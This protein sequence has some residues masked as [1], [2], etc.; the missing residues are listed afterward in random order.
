[1]AATSSDDALRWAD[2][3]PGPI[4]ISELVAITDQQKITISAKNKGA[5]TLYAVD[6]ARNI[7]ASLQVV[8]GNFEKHPGMRVDLIADVCRGSD[9]FRIHAL[10]R[11]LHNQYLGQD[12]NGNDKYSNGDNVF[13]QNAPPN[14]SSDPQIGNMTCGIV[15]RFRT[16]QVFPKI[17]APKPDWYRVGAIH[18]PLSSRLTDRKQVKYRSERIETLRGQIIR[19]L[20]NGEA[21]RVG[22]LDDPTGMVP[23]NGDLVAYRGGGHTVVIVGYSTD[24]MQFLYIDPWGGGSMMEYQGGIAGNTFPGKCSQIGKLIVTYD[25]DRR[26]KK[27]DTANNIIREHV[28]TQG[29]FTYAHNNY[30]EV[31]SAPFVVPGRR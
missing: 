24:G 31:V 18:E 12:A 2:S 5:T 14:I 1:M 25:P 28:D 17:V 29:S 30:L 23:E 11:M 7:K 27:T 13:E 9:P 3:H 10:Q 19:A 8:A 20:D 15:A 26:V 21:V 6:T 22:V 4:A 16:E